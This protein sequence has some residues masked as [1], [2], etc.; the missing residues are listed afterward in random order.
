MRTSKLALASLVLITVLSGCGGGDSPDTASAPAMVA[1]GQQSALGV[2]L[3]NSQPTHGTSFSDELLGPDASRWFASD[4]NNGGFFLNGWHPDQLAFEA[5]QLGITLEADTRNLTEGQ[6][7]V[8]GEYRTFDTYAWGTYS[9]RLVAS[10]TPGTI[11][12]FFLYTGPAEGTRHDEIDVEIKGD[13]PTKLSVNYWTDGVQHPTVID[14]GFDASAAPH[15]YAFAWSPTSLRWFVD[16]KLVH[17]ETGTRGPLPEVPGHIVLSLWGTVGTA[18]WSTDYQVS[19]TPSRMRVERVAFE[20]EASTPP[21]ATTTLAHVAG[22]SGAASV[23][24]KNWRAAATV[25]VQDGAGAPVANAVVSGGFSVGGTGLA[26]TTGVDGRCTI[27]SGTIQKARTSSTFSVA[28]IG[29]T[30][31]AY[32]ADANVLTSV[33]IARP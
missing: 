29:G 26:C 20:A 10:A 16:G 2:I 27:T 15:D 5:G 21:P 3:Q 22:L 18:P 6:P 11:T 32:R 1:A 33:T 7:A 14:L 8:S 23:S 30:G 24:G 25:Q 17:E 4:W 12:A 13:D 31:L 28:G 19:A 9:A